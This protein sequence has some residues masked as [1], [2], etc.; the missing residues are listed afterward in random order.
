MFYKYWFIV[1]LRQKFTYTHIY[2]ARAPRVG[3]LSD[4]AR[5]TSV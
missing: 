2:Y 5:L 3:A 1:D 4:D